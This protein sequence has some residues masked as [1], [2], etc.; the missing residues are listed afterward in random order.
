MYKFYA[1]ICARGGSKGI[2]KKNLLKLNGI[3]LIGHSILMAKKI[4][5]IQKVFVST[6]NIEIAEVSRKYNAKI[7]FIRDPG[8]ATDT[9]REWDVYKNMLEY[10]KSTHDLPDAVVMLSPTAPLRSVIDVQNSI[11]LYKQNNC[12]G[13][14]SV[15]ESHRNPMFNMIKLDKKGY[16]A[17]AIPSK[18]KFYRRQD[19]E[20]FFDITT[21]CNVI[22]SNYFFQYD[23]LLDGRIVCNYV[24]K[25]R[26][27][28][29]DD[30]LDFE[31]AKFI[32]EN[33]LQNIFS[34]ESK[35]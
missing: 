5:S 17:I 33:N 26:S 7:P 32:I 18:T 24:P 28:D 20:S 30:Q 13:V 27:I 8:L 29:I 1:I 4:K 3:P 19:A 21:V 22:N 12:H 25:I 6:D 16:A 10:L 31:W 2:A 11:N 34:N 14:I 35:L 15:T 9:S 23:H